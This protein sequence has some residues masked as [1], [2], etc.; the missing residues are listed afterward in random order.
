MRAIL[1]KGQSQYDALRSFIDYVAAGL[2]ELGVKTT[3]IDLLEKDAIQR[4]NTEIKSEKVDFFLSFNGMGFNF[5]TDDGRS[6]YEV[7]GCKFVS[8]YVDHPLHHMDRIRNSPKNTI[9]TF[10]DRDHLDFARTYLD[11]DG[12]S[13][14]AFLPHG[15]AGDLRPAPDFR[16]GQTKIIFSGSF[17]NNLEKEWRNPT[18]D[19]DVGMIVDEVWREINEFADLSIDKAVSKV[20]NAKGLVLKKEQLINLS[21]VCFSSIAALKTSKN[22]LSLLEHFDQ[23]GI[24]VDVYGPATWDAYCRKSRSLIY[25]GQLSL[26]DTIEKSGEYHFVLNDNN[27]FT[28]GSHERFYN[29][30]F[31][32]AI[33]VTPSNKYYEELNGGE[34]GVLFDRVTLTGLPTS[35][36]ELKELF[37][38][39][40]AVLEKEID[41]LRRNHSWAAR[42]ARII[43]LVKLSSLTLDKG[44]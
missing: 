11:H 24:E 26:E 8:I 38:K 23:K 34:L 31:S 36:E 19:S 29:S 33:P 35:H 16:N 44:T 12:F 43:Q 13:A 1:Y 22:R 37:V 17:K 30:L 9:A 27:D 20:I 41:D 5:K 32:G 4:I 10:I 3:V 14:L 15:G 40:R 2:Q 7:M 28:D 18:F 42:A 6:I 25:K 39:K 21:W